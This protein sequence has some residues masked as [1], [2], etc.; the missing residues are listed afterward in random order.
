MIRLAVT[1]L[2][3]SLLGGVAVADRDHD[4]RDN[5][6]VVRD[7]RAQPA[8]VNRPAQRPNRRVIARRPIYVSNGQYVFH[9]GIRRSYTRPVIRTHYY[10]VRYRPQIIVENHAPVPGY[11]WVGGNWSWSGR[12]WM[13]SDGHF[14]PDMQY[15]NYYDDGSYDYSLHVSG[16]IRIQ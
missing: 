2:T 11:I 13:W 10:N 12:E 6:P 14:A 16:G 7:N 1:A 3:F 9:D 5:R 15:S 4:R 8:R